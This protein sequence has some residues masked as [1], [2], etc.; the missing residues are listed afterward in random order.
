M[1]GRQSR[2]AERFVQLGI[3]GVEISPAEAGVREATRFRAGDR[4]FWVLLRR[5]WSGWRDAVGFVRPATVVAWH[6]EGWRIL[7][8]TRSRGKPGRPPISS[9][10]RDPIRRLCRENRLWGSPRIS[11]RTR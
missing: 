6:R 10:V 3:E 2:D 7:W 5:P 9:E 8:R 1:D 11:V 4:I